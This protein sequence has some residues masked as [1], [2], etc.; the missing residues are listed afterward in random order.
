MTGDGDDHMQEGVLAGDDVARGIGSGVAGLRV[1]GAG[2]LRPSV[3]DLVR[4]HGGAE[5]QVTSGVGEG[6][7]LGFLGDRPAADLVDGRGDDEPGDGAED[8]ADGGAGGGARD[9]GDEGDGRRHQTPQALE[10]ASVSTK[11]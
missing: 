10:Q 1:E 11:V 7:G 6:G 9:G 4:L 8:A 5:H 2:D 3:D